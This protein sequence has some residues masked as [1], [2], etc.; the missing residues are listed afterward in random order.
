MKR[1]LFA[2]IPLLALVALG[3][4]S[5]AAWLP[6]ATAPATTSEEEDAVIAAMAAEVADADASLEPA[7]PALNAP[8][9]SFLD[10]VSR[11]LSPTVRR[12][13]RRREELESQLARLPNVPG[14]PTSDSIG[15]HSQVSE[16]PPVQPK[17]VQIDLG[18]TRNFDAIVLVAAHAV[19]GS[20]T[21]PGYGFPIRF[22]ID[23][24]NDATFAEFET[25][26]D[27]TEA[28]FPNPG[29]HPVFIET[30][31]GAGRYVRVTATQLWRDGGYRFAL[32]ELMVLAGRLNLA[33]GA[34]VTALD[35]FESPP[36]WGMTLLTDGQSILGPPISK[37]ASLGNGF[38][39]SNR[40]TTTRW[41]QIDLGASYPIEEIRL[42]PARPSNLPARTSY[43]FPLRFRIEVAD[44]PGFEGAD[45]L[46][47]RTL[48]DFP[49]PGDNPVIFNAHGR[50][51]RV[52]RL[53]ATR[54]WFRQAETALALAELEI[55]SGGKNVALGAE[56]SAADSDETGTWS[57]RFLVDGANSQAVLSDLGPWLK[58][59]ARRPAMEAELAA[60]K[61]Q[62]AQQADTIL[63]RIAIWAGVAAVLSVVT[64]MFLS[65]RHRRERHRDVQRLRERIARDLHDEI[66]SSLG[67]IALLS[68]MA[69]D[70]NLSREEL[71]RDLAAI[72]QI[73]ESSVD[74][75][76]A[77]VAFIRPDLDHG[78]SLPARMKEVAQR[79]LAGRE[80]EF[81]CPDDFPVDRLPLEFRFHLLLIFKEALHN[82]LKHSGARKVL[83]ALEARAREM[84]LRIRD[85]GRG[86]DEKFITP[87]SGLRNL[88]QRAERMGARIDI[89]SA[90]NAGTEI[91]LTAK[92][93]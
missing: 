69:Q 40:R 91:E 79:M 41:V 86:F 47:D 88:R 49:N 42:H 27:Y 72:Q 57:K 51:A 77:I 73:S 55:F 44:E 12:L 39:S 71:V 21:G 19:S 37:T 18:E 11:L 48:L 84:H 68:Q 7:S 10:R 36:N 76:R 20:Q 24:G 23:I 1:R 46:I 67:S 85:D 31:N 28:D 25:I 29:D 15:Y 3:C 2:S 60:V 83:I 75:M 33:A 74:S 6:A 80:F 89:R 62:M 5:G 14:Y 32:G 13:N 61:K 58:D 8:H 43:G 9:T 52:V 50:Y 59:L 17:W 54:P 26:A 82:I 81:Q 90:P 66:G 56:V 53:T 34:K 35:T 4:L 64:L 63:T 65:W 38:R 22:R 93:A 92:L 30:P 78:A 45:T 70:P 87:G 16:R